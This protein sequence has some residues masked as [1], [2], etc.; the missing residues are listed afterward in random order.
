ML[1][2]VI[3]RWRG[4]GRWPET[5]AT[6]TSYEVISDGSDKQGPPSAR[7]SFFYRDAT[8]SLQSGELVVDSLT[9]LHNISVNDTFLIRF[10]PKRPCK[11][12]STEAGSLFTE[13]RLLFWLS[14][15]LLLLAFAAISF[16]CISL[17][18]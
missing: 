13:F 16:E 18:R 12:Y 9:S 17:A 2:R 11:F 7:I 6:V 4:I 15:A 10:N 1:E 3:A 8:N 5:D 14:L